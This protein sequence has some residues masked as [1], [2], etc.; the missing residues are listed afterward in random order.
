MPKERNRSLVV[1]SRGLKWKGEVLL[2][3]DEFDIIELRINTTKAKQLFETGRII[4]GDIKRSHEERLCF[5][6]P[7]PEPEP[8]EVPPN[9][10]SPKPPVEP[11]KEPEKVV[12]TTP[13]EKTVTQPSKAPVSR[14]TRARR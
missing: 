12:A 9:G 10:A 8:E 7:E 11:V 3:G 1:S 6:V 13:E 2:P 4:Y 14:R 5:V